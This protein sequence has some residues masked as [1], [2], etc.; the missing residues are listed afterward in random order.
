MGEQI[1]KV[2]EAV[3]R[4][5]EEKSEIEAKIAGI[6]SFQKLVLEQPEEAILELMKDVKKQLKALSVI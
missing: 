2:G 4:W 3:K 1:A 6:E 5:Q